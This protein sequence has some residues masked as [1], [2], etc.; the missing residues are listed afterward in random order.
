[1]V[2][3]PL[4]ALCPNLNSPLELFKGYPNVT[5]TLLSVTLLM[6]NALSTPEPP[7]TTLPATSKVCVGFVV[8][9]PTPPET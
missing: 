5:P 2:K 9:I 7:I 1:M 3:F 8:P 6:Y 4:P